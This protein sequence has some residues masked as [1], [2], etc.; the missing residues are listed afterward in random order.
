VTAARA[1]GIGVVELLVGTALGLVVLSLLTA[2]VGVGGRLLLA[3]GARGEVEDTVQI[4]LEALLFDARRA[5]YDPGAAGIEPL[6]EA[7]ADRVTF[8]ADLDANGAVDFT[9]EETTSHACPPG[10]GRLSRIIGR[11]SL[12]L[13]DGVT[14]CA[15]GY[16]GVDGAPLPLPPGGLDAT[17]RAAVTAVTLDLT[18]AASGLHDPTDRRTVVALR[19]RP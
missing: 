12:P 10:T 15:F 7:R 8:Q 16:L 17:G 4:A 3:S 5:G 2:L 6:T 14:R 19:R 1:A 11:Q 18:L 13:A 9:S